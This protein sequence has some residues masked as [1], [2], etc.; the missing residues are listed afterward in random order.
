MT[1]GILTAVGGKGGSSK[2]TTS[3]CIAGG[4]RDFGGHGVYV[5]TDDRM[6]LN[7]EESHRWYDVV[8]GRSESDL[9]EWVGR[10]K[11]MPDNGI[12]VID[13]AGG[14]DERVMQWIASISDIVLIP[15]TPDEESVRCAVL[16]AGRIPGSLILPNRWSTNAK[17]AEVD[18]DY[19]EMAKHYVGADRVLPPLPSVHS[20]AE[21]VR[22]DFSGEILPAARSFCRL[23]AGAMVAMLQEKG[24]WK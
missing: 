22:S 9:R 4:V 16:D 7:N 2:T 21:F 1:F 20:V 11:A 12:L 17:A 5:L 19:I 24:V 15:M 18:Q 6:L 8:D 10:A 23:I 13:G 14:S 3:H